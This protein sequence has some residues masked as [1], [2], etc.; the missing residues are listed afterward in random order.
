MAE[1]DIQDLER[2][3]ALFNRGLYFEAHEAWED[4][5]RVES[6]RRRLLLHGLI[7]AAAGFVKLTRGEPRGASRLLEKA[8]PKLRET[9]DLGRFDIGALLADLA[10]WLAVT[11][12]MERRGE[13]A[14]DRARLPRLAARGRRETGALMEPA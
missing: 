5:W 7:Q 10:T 1:P 2:G 6:G 12:D 11:T 8:I 4:G 9:E 14:F 3:A 13:N